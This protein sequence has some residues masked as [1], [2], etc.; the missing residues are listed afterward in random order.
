MANQVKINI[1][2]VVTFLST[3]GTVLFTPTSLAQ[4]A[5]RVSAQWDRGAYP[6]PLRYE[7]RAKAKAAATVVLGDP[8]VDIYLATADNATSGYQDGIAGGSDAALTPID[9]TRNMQ[10]CGSLITEATA[11][12]AVN[13]SGVIEIVARYVSVVFVN[14]LSTAVALSA[15]ATDMGFQLTPILDEIQ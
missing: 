10:W 3:G 14:R 5:A 8:L 11:A 12:G 13:G 15:T 7:W 4:N 2:T 1:G 6:L 9:K